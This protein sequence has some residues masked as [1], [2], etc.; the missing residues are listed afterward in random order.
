MYYKFKITNTLSAHKNHCSSTNIIITL[1][2]INIY[3]V[4]HFSSYQKYI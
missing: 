3:N 2:N 1:F 4:Y